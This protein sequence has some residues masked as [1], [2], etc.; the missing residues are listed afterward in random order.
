MSY[1]RTHDVGTYIKQ[2]NTLRQCYSHMNINI[3]FYLISVGI[4]KYK[5]NKLNVFQFINNVVLKSWRA[6]LEITIIHTP[7]SL[8]Q[9]GVCVYY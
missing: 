8:F 9:L 3:N 2:T 1:N 6:T 7:V 4:F 5:S